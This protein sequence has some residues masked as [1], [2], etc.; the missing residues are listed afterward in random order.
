MK[1]PWSG[2]NDLD[3]SSIRKSRRVTLPLAATMRSVSNLTSAS[4]TGGAKARLNIFMCE[5]ITSITKVS[6]LAILVPVVKLFGQVRFICAVLAPPPGIDNLF[7]KLNISLAP[8]V[9]IKM[10]ASSLAVKFM[11][12]PSFRAIPI[13]R[14]GL[15]S[16]L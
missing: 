5:V 3:A 9:V 11:T 4:G 1:S 6:L 14:E 13:I 15:I 16:R 2:S 10:P 8:P 12:R 7:V